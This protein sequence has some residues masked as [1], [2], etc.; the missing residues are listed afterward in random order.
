MQFHS[1]NLHI[2]RNIYI[3]HEIYPYFTKYL[4]ISRNIYIFMV[5]ISIWQIA[6]ME[7]VQNHFSSKMSFFIS[8]CNFSYG[9]IC[10]NLHIFRFAYGDM[11]VFFS[12]IWRFGQNMEISRIL[13]TRNRHYIVTA[14]LRFAIKRN[15]KPE[16]TENR[17]ANFFG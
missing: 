1:G 13:M 4:D 2:S 12:Q 16:L 6:N 11:G 14:N 7:M 3:F 8:I 15:R 5:K 17:S 9:D 10:P